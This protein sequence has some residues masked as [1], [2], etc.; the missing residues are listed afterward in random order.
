MQSD[1]T[2]WMEKLFMSNGFQV[3]IVS[4]EEIAAS[5]GV[6]LHSLVN[7][8]TVL[9]VAQQLRFSDDQVLMPLY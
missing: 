7:N 8:D 1:L 6:E 9:F 5:L 3:K 4:H 2:K